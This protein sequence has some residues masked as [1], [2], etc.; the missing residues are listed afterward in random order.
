M[1]STKAAAIVA[2]AGAGPV[3]AAADEKD[4]D[5]EEDEHAAE[6]STLGRARAGG[7]SGGSGWPWAEQ[8]PS[9]GKQKSQA[10]GAKEE[11]AGGFGRGGCLRD[12]EGVVDR[13]AGGGI[14]VHKIEGA[15]IEGDGDGGIGGRDGA[16]PGDPG[17]EQRM[18]GCD[19]IVQ[20]GV[21]A[22]AGEEDDVGGLRRAAVDG[23]GGGEGEFPDELRVGDAFERREA[24]GDGVA[25]AGED[26]V[27]DG[28]GVGGEGE[29]GERQKGEAGKDRAHESILSLRSGMRKE[30][31]EWGGKSIGR[32]RASVAGS[33]LVVGGGGWVVLGV[34]AEAG[35]DG[36][37]FWLR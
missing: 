22:A 13:W 36:V 30:C 27:V 28:V 35:A 18:V 17:T 6:C 32:R 3:A 5:D 19:G 29:G 21:I 20:G 37:W 2:P 34:L 7:G 33:G 14:R 15:E 23:D 11:E 26:E 9:A 24:P 25:A 12:G 31:P 10:G 8:K 16:E 1:R 4:Q